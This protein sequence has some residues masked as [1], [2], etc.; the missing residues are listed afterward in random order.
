MAEA[1][2]LRVVVV[3]VVA[4]LVLLASFLVEAAY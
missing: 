4:V 2:R 3:V 1:S